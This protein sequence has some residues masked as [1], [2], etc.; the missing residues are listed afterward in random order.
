[1]WRRNKW[2]AMCGPSCRL[3]ECERE[4]ERSHM[5]TCVRGY[6]YIRNLGS[7]ELIECATWRMGLRYK[8]D[9]CNWSR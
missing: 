1:M 2:L 8:R 3:L 5:E 6:I 9:E 7:W 4:C